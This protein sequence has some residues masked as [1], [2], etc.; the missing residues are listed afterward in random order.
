ML[1]QFSDIVA[2]DIVGMRSTKATND[3][4]KAEDKIEE[5]YSKLSDAILA[6]LDEADGDGWVRPWNLGAFLP[7]NAKTKQAYRGSNV[8]NLGITQTDAQYKHPMWGTYKMWQELGGQVQKGERGTIIVHWSPME[9]EIIGPG[10]AIETRKYMRPRLHNVFNIDQVTGVDPEKYELP[11]LSDEQRVQRMDSVIEELGATIRE[12]TNM[13]TR[14]GGFGLRAFYNP[15][16]DSISLPPFSTFTEPIGYYQTAMHELVHW[17]G[18]SSRLDRLNMT[19]FGNEDYAYEEL[20]AEFGSAFLMG[21]LGME[22]EPQQN[23]SAYIKGWKRKIKDDPNTVKNA[24]ADAQKAVNYI[25]NNSSTFRDEFGMNDVNSDANDSDGIL[26]VAG[27]LGDIVKNAIPPSSGVPGPVSS[28]R[29]MVG[30]RSARLSE[31]MDVTD[32]DS[33]CQSGIELRNTFGRP[34]LE[35]LQKVLKD[36]QSALSKT[37]DEWQ[38]TGIWNGQ[39]NGVALPRTLYPKNGITRNISVEELSTMGDKD[40]LGSIFN[41]YL[42]QIEKQLNH[43]NTRLSD[44]NRF[45]NGDDI[46]NINSISIRDLPTFA[47][48]AKRG[49]QIRNGRSGK[50]DGSWSLTTDDPDAVWLIH[51]GAPVLE[52]GV[53]YPS[54]TLPK[55]GDGTYLRQGMDTQ[56]LNGVTRRNL[57]NLYEEAQRDVDSYRLALKKYDE[58][59]IWDGEGLANNLKLPAFQRNHNLFNNYTEGKDDD[60]IS[61]Q[62]LRETAQSVIDGGLDTMARNQYAYGQAKAGKEHLSY[63]HISMGP[64]TGY[65]RDDFPTSKTYLVRVPKK[66]V[67]SGYPPGEYQIFGTRTPVASFEFPSRFNDSVEVLD[68]AI[69]LFEKAAQKHISRDKSPSGMLSRR[70]LVSLHGKT[71]QEVLN[72]LEIDEAESLRGMEELKTAIGHLD[73]RK[74]RKAPFH[75]EVRDS[76]NDI[77]DSIAVSV[78]SD[79]IIMLHSKPNPIFQK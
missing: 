59:G 16:D 24:I 74:I 61:P 15:T 9:K 58:T 66:E 72:T 45:E 20:V 43:V 23:H 39:T 52:N 14:N 67:I 6:S 30:M 41:N 55:G 1:K 36:E 19:E 57:I 46:S 11:A 42:S 5:M 60:K 34:D 3:S 35:K 63:S 10:G 54:F 21:I 25:L 70:D 65:V 71:L 17:T 32:A 76:V 44:L 2:G 73:D 8:F 78:S 29:D 47:A 40:A 68:V 33:F 51:T 48:L 49:K 69:A 38:K 4:K 28:G 50:D 12:S 22:A 13:P 56:R 18:H 37:I 62:Y 77:I 26:P 75:P 7:R 31:W 64:S 53:L 79:G 27:E